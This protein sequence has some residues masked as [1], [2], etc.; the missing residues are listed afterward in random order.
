MPV[1]QFTRPSPF[2]KGMAEVPIPISAEFVQCNIVVVIWVIYAIRDH[3][4]KMRCSVTKTFTLS[5]PEPAE[6]GFELTF[7]PAAT[8]D[9][10]DILASAVPRSRKRQAIL[11][12]ITDADGKK[13]FV[14][15]WTDLSWWHLLTWRRCL[16]S[17]AFSPSEA[18][19]VYTAEA[20]SDTVE[21][22][23]DDP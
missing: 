1:P 15:I 11:R 20:N 16:P 5:T 23:Q 12:E 21:D 22:L 7:T 19:L 6:V 4:R 18:A 8:Q 3:E 14:E 13:R 9:A 10:L 17:L 2:Y